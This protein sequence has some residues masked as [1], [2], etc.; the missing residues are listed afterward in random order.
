MPSVIITGADRGFGLSLCREFLSRGWTVF[1]GKFLNDYNFLEQECEKNRNFHF[2]PLDVSDRESVAKAR[3]FVAEKTGSLD[4]L[5][6][7]AALMGQVQCSI[8][9]PPMDLQAPWEYFCVN[10]LG[11]TIMV[12]YF[13]PLLDKGSVK[14]LCFVSSEVSCIS[15]MKHRIGNSYPYPMSKSSMNMSVR[16]MHNLLFPQGYT[17]RLYHP[18]WMKK[19]EPDGSLSEFA[20]HDPAITAVHAAKYFDTPLGDEHRLVMYDYMSQEWPY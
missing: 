8:D 1:G 14:R 19:Q 17:F 20:V 12:E 11:P 7:N 15:L 9:E 13:L 5:I 4:M 18:G 16:L 3:D 6:S 10:A 2:V